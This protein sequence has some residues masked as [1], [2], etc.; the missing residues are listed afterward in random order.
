MVQNGQRLHLSCSPKTTLRMDTGGMA[1]TLGLLIWVALLL[2]NSWVV[3][4][5]TDGVL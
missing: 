5:S 4:R 2:A 1:I 3:L